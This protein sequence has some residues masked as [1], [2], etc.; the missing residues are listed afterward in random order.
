MAIDWRVVSSNREDKPMTRSWISGAAFGAITIG[1]LWAA[2]AYYEGSARAQPAAPAGG[3]GPAPAGAVRSAEGKIIVKLVR[4]DDPLRRTEYTIKGVTALDF[5][6]GY[7]VYQSKE[8][9]QVAFAEK[10]WYFTWATGVA[11]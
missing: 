10:T 7:I 2:T 9:G 1:A 4:Q 8:G 3:A 6:P 5:Y 11:P